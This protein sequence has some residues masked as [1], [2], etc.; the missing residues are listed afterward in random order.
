MWSL[1]AAGIFLAVLGAAS[2]A[3]P[4]LT[5]LYPAAGQQG[6][7]VT[8]TPVGKSDPWPP[9]VWVDAPGITFTP[10]KAKGKFDVEIAKDA[11]PGPHLVRLFNK[12]GASQPRFFIVSTEPE[13]VEKEPNDDYKAPQKIDALPATISGRLDKAGDVD[14]FAVTLKKGQALTAWVEAYVLASTFDGMLRIVDESGHELA[15][16]HDGRTLD[17]DLTW[18]APRDGTFIVQLMGFVYPATAAVTLTG[19]DGCVYRLHLTTASR[20]RVS[21]PPHDANQAAEIAEQE[22]NDTIDKAQSVAVPCSISGCINQRGDEDRFA[23][24]A[25]KQKI[26]EL[27]VLGARAGAPLD[28][29]LKIE[30]KDG[31]QLTRADDTDGSR[32]PRITWTAPSSGTFTVA[33]GD[34]T[35]HGGPDFLYH[36][37]IAEAVPAV[38]GTAANHAFAVA[39]GKTSEFKATVKGANG[40][41]AKLQLAAKNLPE[42]VSAPEVDVPEKG[43]E[44]TLKLTAD[45]S[46]A[47]ASRPIQLV[48]RET[49]SGAEHAVIYSMTTTG[50]NNGVP[51]G[52]TELVINSTDQLWLTVTASAE[53][54]EAP[55]PEPATPAP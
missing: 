2:A 43:G 26:Y 48:L 24:T 23:F 8:I 17:P 52:Y 53:K 25:E 45:A 37:N 9:Q 40:F 19:G 3:E 12:D 39:A 55:K 30:N 4:T 5:H 27:N 32:D 34:V 47:A 7:T 6:T 18:E 11:A 35:H 20:P 16:N 50:E 42:G 13:L 49:E 36:L 44:V 54:K 46:A 31:K 22:P 1:R 33:I 41:K 15:F 14:S 29:W 51:Q 28:A 21:F 10:A 38:T